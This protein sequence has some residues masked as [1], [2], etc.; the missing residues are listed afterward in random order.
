MPRLTSPSPW[1]NENF[2]ATFCPQNKN[3]K[4]TRSTHFSIYR[5]GSR[6]EAIPTFCSLIISKQLLRIN[7]TDW[8]N[9]MIRFKKLTKM[10]SWLE[11]FS[12]T[13][14]STR[15]STILKWWYRLLADRRRRRCNPFVDNA[16]HFHADLLRIGAYYRFSDRFIHLSICFICPKM[17]VILCLSMG[18]GGGTYI[19]LPHCRSW[20]FASE[21]FMIF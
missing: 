6:S 13:R 16:Q 11:D 5:S 1:T 10:V 20:I 12:Y 19:R 8:Q 3:I 9:I 14:P 21:L 18:E 4:K 17:C 7:N 2:L 15:A